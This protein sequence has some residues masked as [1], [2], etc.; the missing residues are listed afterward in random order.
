MHRLRQLTAGVAI[1]AA[2]AIAASTVPALADP[3][4]NSGKAATSAS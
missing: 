2:V 4:S 1:A 3:I